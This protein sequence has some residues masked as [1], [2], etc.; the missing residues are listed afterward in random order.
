MHAPHP[1]KLYPGMDLL[2]ASNWL[3]PAA[4]LSSQGR[5]VYTFRSASS[6]GESLTTL[7]LLPCHCRVCKLGGRAGSRSVMPLRCVRAVKTSSGTGQLNPERPAQVMTVSET[8][9]STCGCQAHSAQTQCAHAF[10]NVFTFRGT[11]TFYVTT[12]HGTCAL[13]ADASQVA[14]AAATEVFV[15][16]QFLQFSSDLQQLWPM[17]SHATALTYQ[18]VKGIPS[19]QQWA[20]PETLTPETCSQMVLAGSHQRRFCSVGSG[21]AGEC[22]AR[23]SARGM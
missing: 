6:M 1:W 22:A 3:P 21:A 10:R 8:F 9:M 16:Q 5:T 12:G 17:H 4:V 15:L 20:L 11:C 19:R 18:L 2:R 7:L 13:E 23:R 14:S